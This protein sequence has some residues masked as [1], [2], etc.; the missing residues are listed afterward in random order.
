MADKDIVRTDRTEAIYRE[1]MSPHMIK[2]REIL[3][4]YTFYNF[5]LGTWLPPR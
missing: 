4:T 2:M 3:L 5:D 1:E